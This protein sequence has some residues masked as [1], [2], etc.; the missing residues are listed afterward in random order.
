M[1]DLRAKFEDHIGDR[2]AFG[3]KRSRKGTYVNPAVANAWKWFQRGAQQVKDDDLARRVLLRV[4]GLVSDDTW[5]MVADEGVTPP[6]PLEQMVCEMGLRLPGEFNEVLAAL[7][8]L[9]QGCEYAGNGRWDT[10]KMPKEAVLTRA[11]A[12]VEKY[13]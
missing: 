10:I 13:R 5:R 8:S 12:V 9:M 3:L 6:W 1:S 4:F 11:L 2:D 7:N